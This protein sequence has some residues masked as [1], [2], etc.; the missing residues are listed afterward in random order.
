MKKHKMNWVNVDGCYYN[1]LSVQ[2]LQKTLLK[3]GLTENEFQ[4]RPQ[5]S[6]Q[7]DKNMDVQTV[8]EIIKK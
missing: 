5:T 6:G 4:I 8:I 3:N 1:D 7:K 2:Q